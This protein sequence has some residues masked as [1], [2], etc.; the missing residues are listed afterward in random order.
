MC[1]VITCQLSMAHKIHLVKSL[2]YMS[3]VIIGKLRIEPKTNSIK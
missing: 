1:A 3:A 2:P